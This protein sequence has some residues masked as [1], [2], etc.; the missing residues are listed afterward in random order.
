M[1]DISSPLSLL[2]GQVATALASDLGEAE[3]RSLAHLTGYAGSQLVRIA[4]QLQPH[5]VKLRRPAG[6]LAT[7]PTLKPTASL[8]T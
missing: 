7:A 8:R 6:G 4:N 5:I 1:L 3:V 2:P